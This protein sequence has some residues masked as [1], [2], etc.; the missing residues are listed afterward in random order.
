M[1]E[2]CCKYLFVWSICSHYESRIPDSMQ[3][4]PAL[5]SVCRWNL[6]ILPFERKGKYTN[7]KNSD[8]KI[9]FKSKW[10]KVLVSYHP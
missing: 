1:I 10:L 4:N 9:I 5:C 6:E 8:V 3:I 2:L 7:L